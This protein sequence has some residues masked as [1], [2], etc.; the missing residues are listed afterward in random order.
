MDTWFC[1]GEFLSR[2]APSLA[3]P[4]KHVP[5]P[6]TIAASEQRKTW[7]MPHFLSAIVLTERQSPIMLLVIPGF[8]NAETDRFVASRHA[9]H[10]KRIGLDGS[11][12]LVWTRLV[13]FDDDGELRSRFPDFADR[14]TIPAA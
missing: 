8:H 11:G 13:V 7:H 4:P 10:A 5:K 6:S 12:L 3:Q 1:L 14:D 2:A 9:N